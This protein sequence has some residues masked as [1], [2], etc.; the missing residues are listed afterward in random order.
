MRKFGFAKR[1]EPLDGERG[2]C[3]NAKRGLA[4]KEEFMRK[5][6]FAKRS[7]PLDGERENVR[8]EY[9]AALAR[10]HEIRNDF[11]FVDDE[12]LTDAL[13]FE[14]NAVLKL[15]EKIIAEAK[16][17]KISIEFYEILPK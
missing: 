10:L 1:S 13:I 11:D 7:E 17:R 2:M 5:F 12:A 14:E 15:I 16:L 6:G 8:R 3:V 9:S 4:P